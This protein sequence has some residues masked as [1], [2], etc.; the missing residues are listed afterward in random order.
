VP[1]PKLLQLLPTGVPGLDRIFLGGIRR[2]NLIL[3]SGEPGSGK[4]LLGLEFIYR[5]ITT[6][7]EPGLIVVFESDPEML[8]RD[9]AAFGWDLAALEAQG[10]LKIILTSPQVLDHELRSPD[11]V[12]L[13]TAAEMGAKRIFIDS[14]AMLRPAP[15]GN[16]HAPSGSGPGIYREMLQQL[17]EG[18]RREKLMA[19]VAHETGLRSE[20][21][22][23]LEVAEMIADTVIRLQRAQS[24]SGIYRRIEIHKSRGQDFDAGEHTLTITNGVGIEVYRRVQS[25]I[26]ETARQP[27]S[28]TQRSAVGMEML[29]ALTGGGLYE[30]S[31]TLVTGNSGTGKSILGMQVC[32]EG[33]KHV[34]KRSLLVSADEHPEQ[35]LRNS[36]IL[37]L[38]LREQVEAGNVRILQASP[39]ELEVDIHFHRICAEIQEHGIDRL[40]VDGL[41]A[42]RNAIHDERRFREFM[43]GLLAFTKQ[44]LMTS[45]LCYEHPELFGITRFM[46]DSAISSIV[47][48]IILLNYVELGHCMHRAITVAKARGCDHSLVTREYNIG[49]GGIALV[50]EGEGSLPVESFDR[51]FNLLS[52]AP[53]RYVRVRDIVDRE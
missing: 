3:L 29:D 8:H 47:D 19:M 4:S 42:I 35:I 7:G 33:A 41:T 25:V 39:L 26:R 48:N 17:V 24:R 21:A 18:L 16:G 14:I 44:R 28:I 38:G 46:P 30:G 11:S 22:V 27:T 20:A 15:E 45:F 10:K 32:V 34:G 37:G 50:P 13:R 40:V 9:A 31:V 6:F 49:T 43:H 1:D 5:G 23:T 51:Y 53:T 12:L 2:G 52:R 36:D